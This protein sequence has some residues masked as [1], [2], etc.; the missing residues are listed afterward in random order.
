MTLKMKGVL[1]TLPWIMIHR[2]L[3]VLEEPGSLGREY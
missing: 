2:L 3:Q 1:C